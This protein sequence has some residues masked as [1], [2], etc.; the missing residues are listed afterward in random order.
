MTNFI[1][2]SI[3]KSF[4]EK[5]KNKKFDKEMRRIQSKENLESH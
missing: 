2:K 1:F 3:I 5:R 4:F